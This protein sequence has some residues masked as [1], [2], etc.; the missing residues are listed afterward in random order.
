MGVFEQLGT[1]GV[2]ARSACL[3]LRPAL[4]SRRHAALKVGDVVVLSLTYTCSK[5]HLQVVCLV[6]VPFFLSGDLSPCGLAWR[7]VG[8]GPRRR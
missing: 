8:E 4:Q 7:V 6:S 5:K 3:A 1:A 2:E